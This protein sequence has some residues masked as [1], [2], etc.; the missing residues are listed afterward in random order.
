[1]YDD[2]L[3]MDKEFEAFGLEADEIIEGFRDRYGAHRVGRLEED[4]E[5]CDYEEVVELGRS[6]RVF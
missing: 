6:L 5:M 3:A 1:M 2:V 4:P